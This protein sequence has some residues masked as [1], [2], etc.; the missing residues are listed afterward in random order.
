MWYNINTWLMLSNV[1][2]RKQDATAPLEWI[3]SLDSQ[4]LAKQARDPI[5]RPANKQ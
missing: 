4:G 1:N 5:Q 2:V 3:L